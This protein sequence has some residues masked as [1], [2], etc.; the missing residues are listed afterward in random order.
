VSV[1]RESIPLDQSLVEQSFR[2]LK[3]I[4]WEGVAMVEYKMDKCEDV[5]RLM[6]VNP[7]FWGSL[8]LAIDS[9]MNFPLLLYRL[10][11]NEE[12][13]PAFDYEVGVKSRWLLGDLDNLLIQLKHPWSD[14]GNG[15]A[16]GAGRSRLQACADFFKFHEKNT[17]YEVF[18]IDD[19][20]PGLLECKNY[21]RDLLRHRSTPK[22]EIRAR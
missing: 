14:N 10:A 21:V 20:R 7:R 11:I 16:R 12:V 18:K 17:H 15:G 9:G 6:E 4:G 3:A 8:Q 19:P 22:E 1:L 2:L 5:P 13:A